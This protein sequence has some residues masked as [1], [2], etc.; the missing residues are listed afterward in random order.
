MQAQ[1]EENLRAQ[2]LLDGATLKEIKEKVDK[3]KEA[4]QTVTISVP[5]IQ[6]GHYLEHP[7]A[8]GFKFLEVKPS[9]A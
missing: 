9:E 1:L 2:Q 7:E 6:Q 3:L 8:Q 4:A 5:Y